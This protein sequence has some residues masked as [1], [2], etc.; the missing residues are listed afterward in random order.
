MPLPTFAVIIPFRPKA[1]SID[2]ERESKLLQQTIHS[3]LRQ[4]YTSFKIFVVYTDVPSFIVVDE[5]VEYYEFPYGYKRYLELEN[6]A[7]LFE[8]FKSE[9]MV[10]RRWDK[11]RKLCYGSKLAKEAGC[12]YIMAVDA[13][14]LVSKHLFRYLSQDAEKKEGQSGWY[15][16]T[17]YLYRE[18]TNY[19]LKVP[20]NMR[21]LNGSTHI[22]HS[23]LVPIPDFNSLD[24][25][26]YSLFTDHGWI[27]D[28]VLE[29]EGAQLKPVPFAGVVYVAHGANISAITKKEFGLS[30]KAI[31][32]RILRTKML[33]T[34]LRSEFNIL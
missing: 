27:K 20:K 8:K 11:A 26:D 34:S 30:M 7:D 29:Y 4:T 18:G 2:W 14:D 21:F 9:K 22:L 19:L 1:E 12:E 13:D 23:S 31:L 32:K 33:T 16:E 6:R 28:R 10:V 5:R 24:W 15:I 17:G 25:L 3:V